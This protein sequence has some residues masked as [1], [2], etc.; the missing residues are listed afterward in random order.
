M[1]LDALSDTVCD[2][3][4]ASVTTA[5]KRYSTLEKRLR[6]RGVSRAAMSLGNWIP[7]LFSNASMFSVIATKCRGNIQTHC[8][9]QLSGLIR[10]LTNFANVANTYY[11]CEWAAT[12]IRVKLYR[13]WY[14]LQ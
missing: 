14:N 7:F 10:P 6:Y 3:S 5:F 4:I 11:D 2:V 8:Y 9:W 13:P 12:V 1:R